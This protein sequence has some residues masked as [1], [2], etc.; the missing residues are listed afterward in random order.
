MWPNSAR[1]FAV[2]PDPFPKPCY[3]F[4]LVGGDLGCVDHTPSR[5]PGRTVTLRIYVQ[6]GD[7]ARCP[8]RCIR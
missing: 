4:A 7:E 6:P 8:G 1:H 5:R 3:L 2:W